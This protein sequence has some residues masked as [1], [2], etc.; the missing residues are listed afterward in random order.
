MLYIKKNSELLN[1][2]KNKLTLV[3]KGIFKES[4]QTPKSPKFAP[5]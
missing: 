3:T 1:I 4:K 2:K 5:F